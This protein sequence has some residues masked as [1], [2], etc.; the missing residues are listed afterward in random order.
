M[1]SINLNIIKLWLGSNLALI[2]LYIFGVINSLV[3]IIDLLAVLSCCVVLIFTL[4]RPSLRRIVATHRQRKYA[5][6]S[7]L[8]GRKVGFQTT[9]AA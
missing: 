3:L 4:W 6:T 9:L 2:V 1:V 7:K 8:N 5:I